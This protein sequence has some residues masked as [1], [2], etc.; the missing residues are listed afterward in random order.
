MLPEHQH[1]EIILHEHL[2]T[3][4]NCDQQK[5]VQSEHVLNNVAQYVAFA[6]KKLVKVSNMQPEGS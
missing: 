3:Y 6:C 4:C 1:M 5:Q 2:S